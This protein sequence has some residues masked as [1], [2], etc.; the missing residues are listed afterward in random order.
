[1]YVLV[2]HSVTDP[3]TFWTT[4]QAALPNIPAGLTLH[5]TISARDG[6]R[7]TCVWEAESVDAVRA[8]LEP[9]LGSSSKN[10]YSEA[11][12]REGVVV[13]QRYVA[14]SVGG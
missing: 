9:A 14:V 10:D 6:S 1:M 7:A 11:E 3:A 4:A 5:H 2:H 13:P 8:F 12:N